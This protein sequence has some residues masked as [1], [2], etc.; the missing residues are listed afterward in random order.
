M[1]APDG[2]AAV[3]AGIGTTGEDLPVVRLAAQE[4]VTHGRA[5]AL[6]HAF[7]WAAS[8]PQPT[9]I[10]PRAEAEQ[11]IDR[12]LVVA[13]QVSSALPVAEEI[14]EGDAVV[15]L[16]R[17]S[18]SAFLV[19]VGDGGMTDCGRCVPADTPA[20]QVAARA[21]CPV[22]VVRRDPP[23]QGPLLVGVDGS[24]SSRAAL[25]FAFDCAANRSARMLA[26]RVVEPD[27]PADTG[28]GLAEIVAGYRQRYPTVGVE[29]HTVHGDAET[30]LVEQSRSAQLTVVAA[31]GDEPRRGMLGPVAQTLIYHSPAPVLVVRGLTDSAP[32][33]G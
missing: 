25:G 1:S 30:V 5:L 3:V 22:L 4:A 19:A 7:N 29:C 12:A 9:T 11:L 16:I 28:E 13:H 26:V 2:S 24:P 14:V 27:R 17:R 20:V 23:P 31:R 8:T 6:L 15:A 10:G 18:A 32:G 21:D 33:R